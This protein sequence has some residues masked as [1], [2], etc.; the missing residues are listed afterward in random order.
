MEIVNGIGIKSG[1]I[2][3]NGCEE[4]ISDF[5]SSRER[6][7]Q[8]DLTTGV[9]LEVKDCIEMAYNIKNV[10]EYN[11]LVV[12]YLEEYTRG[13]DYKYLDLW[14]LGSRWEGSKYKKYI[15]KKGHY[16]Y[17]HQEKDGY[18]TLKNRLFS[19]LLYLNSV[20]IGGETIFPLHQLISKPESGKVIIWPSGFPYLH[21][22]TTPISDDKYAINSWLVIDYE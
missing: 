13:V 12:E 2:D 18:P 8:G 5:E 9:D 4:L 7:Y 16:N 10:D 17:V 15:K 6:Q 22:A 1:F 11:N 21:Y 3:E 14:Y 20:D 19:C